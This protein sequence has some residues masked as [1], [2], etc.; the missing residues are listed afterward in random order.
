MPEL[1]ALAGAGLVA[2]AL[3][4]VDEGILASSAALLGGDSAARFGHGMLIPSDPDDTPEL[5][6]VRAYAADG[7]FLGT[8][9]RSADGALRPLKVLAP[10]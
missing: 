1:E 8:A 6:L 7:Q 9:S 4:R 10:T 3:L 2:E 5:S